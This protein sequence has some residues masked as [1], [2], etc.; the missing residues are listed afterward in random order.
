MNRMNMPDQ[1]TQRELALVLARERLKAVAP[2]DIAR[3]AGVRY[4][5]EGETSGRFELL[6]LNRPLRVTHPAGL[7]QSADAQRPPNHAFCLLTLHYLAHADGHPLAGRW[8]AFRELPDGLM[9]DRAFRARVEPPLERAFCSRPDRFASAA[10]ALGGRPLAL[11]D[12][13]LTLDAFPRLPMAVILYRGDDELPGAASILFDGAAGHYLPTEDLA[14]LG[15][16]LV[17]SLIKAAP[18]QEP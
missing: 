4:Q 12:A 13:A 11:G 2:F 1:A 3:R 18:A 5:P 8:V 14:V 6:C 10:R 17:G 9:Y 7:V 16:L 15:G